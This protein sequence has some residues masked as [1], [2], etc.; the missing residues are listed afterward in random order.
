[1][2]FFPPAVPN[3][4]GLCEAVVKLRKYHLKRGLGETILM[5]KE[6]YTCLTQIEGLLSSKSL[7]TLDCKPNELRISSHFLIGQIVMMPEHDV[8]HLKINY[9][10]RWQLTR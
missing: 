9:L 1:M 7:C 4:N 3:F 10:S 5:H 2:V 8:T 6:M